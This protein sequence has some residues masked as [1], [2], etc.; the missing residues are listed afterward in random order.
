MEVDIAENFGE[1]SD[2]SIPSHIE[3]NDIEKTDY[4]EYYKFDA[5]IESI[6]NM[7]NIT[8]ETNDDFSNIND[9][10]NSSIISNE[11]LNDNEANEDN[12]NP[13]INNFNDNDNPDEI[14]VT[15]TNMMT[16]EDRLQE[17]EKR[18]RIREIE[19]RE[20]MMDIKERKVRLL[21]LELKRKED[22]LNAIDVDS[23]S[24][25]ESS[26][27]EQLMNDLRRNGSL[28]RPIHEKPRKKKKLSSEDD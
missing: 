26:S 28:K 5:V 11:Y 19:Y 16:L 27:S 15:T 21:E 7:F 24:S 6:V 10:S 13:E 2:S 3:I 12:L 1:E 22:R 9:E 17:R 8:N 20:R 14:S 23:D 18:L 4:N 25:E